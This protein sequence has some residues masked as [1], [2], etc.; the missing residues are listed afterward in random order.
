MLPNFNKSQIGTITNTEL[1]TISSS[2]EAKTGF[3]RFYE[4]C[5]S[6]NLVELWEFRHVIGPCLNEIHG[7]A[8]SILDGDY[9]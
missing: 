2:K 4:T 1:Q 9:M 3:I 5:H 6:L 7:Q 8:F